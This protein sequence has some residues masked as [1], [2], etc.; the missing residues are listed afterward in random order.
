[1]PRSRRAIAASCSGHRGPNVARPKT[2][3]L[4]PSLILR[5]YA[6]VEIAVIAA[7]RCR[8]GSG[9]AGS[10]EHA[11]FDAPASAAELSCVFQPE[12]SRPL[13]RGTNSVAALGVVF[14]RRSDDM[15]SSRI[16]ILRNWTDG[17]PD[18]ARGDAAWRILFFDPLVV[19]RHLAVESDDRVSPLGNHVD[20]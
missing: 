20:A 10:D 19:Q 11:I 17:L 8:D 14:G 5:F 15:T 4:P 12:R 2:P 6:Q 9:R 18:P 16:S 7:H 3:L 13:K 1:M